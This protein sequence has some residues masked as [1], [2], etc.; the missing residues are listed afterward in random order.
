MADTTQVF[1]RGAAPTS[2]NVNIYTAP[3]GTTAVITN[4]VFTNPTGGTLA[5]SIFFD[6]VALYSGFAVPVG[7]TFVGGINLPIF[8]SKSIRAF[9]ASGSLIIHLYGYYAY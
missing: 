9:S 3:P 4:I 8:D 1:Y 5:T 7:T 6:E 2:T